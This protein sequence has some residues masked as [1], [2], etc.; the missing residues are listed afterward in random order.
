MQTIANECKQLQMNAQTI[1]NE[2]KQLQKYCKRLP[3]Y[4]KRLQKYCKQLQ[5]IANN[6]KRFQLIANNCKNIANSCNNLPKNCKSVFLIFRWSASGICNPLVEEG[7]SLSLISTRL[8]LQRDPIT[9]KVFKKI[10][11]VVL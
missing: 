9:L 8:K 6:C 5:N 10:Y 2:C 3:K 11:N 4:C 1:A 7:E